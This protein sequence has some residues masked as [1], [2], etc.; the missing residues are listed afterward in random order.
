MNKEKLRLVIEDD[1]WSINTRTFRD[2]DEAIR[3]IYWHFETICK[4]DLHIN[5]IEDVDD[6]TI[7]EESNRFQFD[8]DWY[9][10]W[11]DTCYLFNS[12]PLWH[13]W[14]KEFR[15]S[16]ERSRQED[17]TTPWDWWEA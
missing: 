15:G 6:Y 1:G 12:N 5:S 11:L 14:T 4:R 13:D 2:K 8:L 10:L 16:A 17:R 3:F 9:H 7:D